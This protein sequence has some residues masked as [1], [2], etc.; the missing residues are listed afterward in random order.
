MAS[1]GSQFRMGS[2][3]HPPQDQMLTVLKSFFLTGRGIEFMMQCYAWQ[4]Y[5]HL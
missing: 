4:T 1:L 3:V 5:S 2:A